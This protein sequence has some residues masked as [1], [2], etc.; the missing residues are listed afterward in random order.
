MMTASGTLMGSGEFD[1][2]EP[3]SDAN[4][5]SRYH[6]YGG[7]DVL[8]RSL[9]GVSPRESSSWS[10]TDRDYHS[11]ERR[12]APRWGGGEEGRGGG[13]VCEEVGRERKGGEERGVRW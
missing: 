8:S 2:L 3:R 5:E 11:L 12:N 9:G 7:G 6:G 1:R 4:G 13:G 10:P